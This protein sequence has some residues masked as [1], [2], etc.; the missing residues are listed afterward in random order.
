MDGVA[1]FSRTASATRVRIPSAR[2][3]RAWRGSEATPGPTV[4][5]TC[6]LQPISPSGAAQSYGRFRTREHHHAA[7]ARTIRSAL[8]VGRYL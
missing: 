7:R 8:R 6:L 5:P 2:W 4:D 1:D 3:W